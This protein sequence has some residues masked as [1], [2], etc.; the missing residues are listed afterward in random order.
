MVQKIRNIETKNHSGKIYV[1]P[2]KQN[3]GIHTTNFHKR[4]ASVADNKS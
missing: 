3:K 1:R 4:K 2:I